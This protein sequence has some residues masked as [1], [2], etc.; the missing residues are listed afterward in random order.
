MNAVLAVRQTDEGTFT[1][2]VYTAQGSKPYVDRTPVDVVD[3]KHADIHSL[4][5]RWGA[6]ARVRAVRRGL[7][8]IEALY[9]RGGGT[10]ASTAPLSADLEILGL[11]RAMVYMPE[12]NRKTLIRLYV[13]GF[14][15]I[16]ICTMFRIRYEKWA[17]WIGTCRSMARN[18]LRRH[19]Y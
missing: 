10:P 14:S 3:P 1:T 17:E 18:L 7:L 2:T 11:E 12:R 13:Y 8:S 6:W 16:S 4:L 5:I 19:G 9:R 15:P